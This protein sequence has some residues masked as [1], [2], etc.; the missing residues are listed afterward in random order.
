MK[1]R[2]KEEINARFERTKEKRVCGVCGEPGP[3]TICIKCGHKI[4]E[5]ILKSK[6]E[7]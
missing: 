7:N 4:L 6:P 2:T 1:P 3:A 5:A